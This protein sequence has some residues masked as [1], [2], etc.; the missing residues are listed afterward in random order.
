[1][2][3]SELSILNVY[4]QEVFV[5]PHVCQVCHLIDLFLHL[6]NIYNQ[7]RRTNK[8][9]L[10]LF[11]RLVLDDQIIEIVFQIHKLLLPL[12]HYDV[13]VLDKLR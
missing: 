2:S 3:D 7:F 13:D 12:S 9:S 11:N 5:F 4:N 6:L 10:T 8:A 1:M